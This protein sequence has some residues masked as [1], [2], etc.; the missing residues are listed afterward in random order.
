MEGCRSRAYVGVR[1]CVLLSPW[2]DVPVKVDVRHAADVACN[3]EFMNFV[4][5]WH[6]QTLP[7]S[8]SCS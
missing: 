5:A 4:A 6:Q 7:P 8:F 2:G 3:R 1:E